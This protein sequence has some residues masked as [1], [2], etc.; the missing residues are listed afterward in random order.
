MLKKEESRQ[1]RKWYLIDAKEQILGKL[2]VQIANLLRGKNRLDFT[3]NQDCGDFVIVINADQ[4]KLSGNKADKE[5]WYWHSGY[6]GGIKSRTGKEM[7]AKKSVKLIRR[8]VKGML[9]KN[10]ALSHALMKKLHVYEGVE[11]KHDAQTPISYQLK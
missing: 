8:S 5:R 10:N 3:P 7:I 1:R 6:I 9:P 11:H 4:V 2:A